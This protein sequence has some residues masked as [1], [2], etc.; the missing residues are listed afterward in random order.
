MRQNRA[1]VSL[2]SWAIYVSG[3]AAIFFSGCGDGRIPTYPV[4]GSVSVNGRPAEGAIVVF[5]PLGTAAEVE[6]LRPAGMAD[7]S[8]K[9]TLTTFEPSDGAPSGEYKVL[10]KWPAPV[11]AAQERDA[12]P[13]GANKG[14]DRLRGKYYSIDSTPLKATI[15]EQSNDLPPFELKST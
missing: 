5:C 15:E 2:P 3:L 13:G 4:T 7:A 14:P 6:H 9:F 8:G 1:T 12:R 10:V 11:P